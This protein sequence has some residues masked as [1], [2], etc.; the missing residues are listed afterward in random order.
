[1]PML[2]LNAARL[3]E[4]ALFAARDGNAGNR[5]CGRIEVVC[6]YALVSH[7]CMSSCVDKRVWL[8]T[9]R[10]KIGPTA[11]GA[12]LWGNLA[13]QRLT[14]G[15]LAADVSYTWVLWLKESLNLLFF[16]SK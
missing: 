15:H 5:H 7:S 14:L 16:D 8:H 1:M 13:M 3:M 6:Q 4:V 2:F 11:L 9:S 10:Q 12:H